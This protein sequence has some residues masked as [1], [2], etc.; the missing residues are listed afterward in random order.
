MNFFDRLPQ[1][2][3]LSVMPTYRCTAECSHCGTLSS[4]RVRTR[5]PLDQMLAAIDQAAEA[6]YALVVFTGGEPTLAG[7]DLVTGIARAASY[8]LLVRIVTNAHWAIG[9]VAAD[10]W[11]G[12]WV[13]AGLTEINYSTGDQHV[14]FVPLERVLCATG[15]AVRAGLRVSIMVETLKERRITQEV[16]EQHP[17]FLQIMREVP[18]AYIRIHESPWMPLSPTDIHEYPGDMVTNAANVSTRTGCNSILST[19]TVEADGRIGACCGLGM[20]LIPELQLGDTSSTSIADADRAA[21]DD[22]LKRWIRVEGTERI[23]A[24]AATHDPEIEWENMYA[25]RCQ[26]C[27]RIYQDPKVRDVIREHHKEKMA[28]VLFGEWLLF[29]FDPEATAGAMEPAHAE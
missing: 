11:I 29:H 7:A 21:A 9:P 25:H 26:A 23:L 8:G 18:G 19:T 2:R 4:P 20:R 12:E 14:R 13:A 3:T 24:W 5:L 28:D 16:V 15:A 1:P 10:R 17:D 6:G 22:F 27:M